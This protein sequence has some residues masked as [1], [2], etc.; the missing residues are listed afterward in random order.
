MTSS[1]RRAT[2]PFFSHSELLVDALAGAADDRAEL[3]LRQMQ[4]QHLAVDL[5]P[6]KAHGQLQQGLG[7]AAFDMTE[8]QILDLLAGPSQALAQDLDQLEADI[9]VPFKTRHQVAPV[10]H[11]EFAV[12]HR[13]RVTAA[14]PA[15]K[16]R[17]LANQLA[18]VDDIENDLLAAERDRADPHT[19]GQNQH[20]AGA[21]RTLGKDFFVLGIALDPRVAQQGVD[22]SGA[23]LSQDGVAL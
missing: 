4:F 3:G 10:Q 12:G 15:V 2:M 19:S 6:A 9:G 21:G 22:F 8:H 5:L 17:D 20:H 16:N 1:L 11:Q 18:S 14:R 13:H 23:Q 7:D